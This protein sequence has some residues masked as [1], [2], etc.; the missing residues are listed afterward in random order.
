MSWTLDLGANLLDASSTRFRV[1]APFAR[2]IDVELISQGHTRVSLHPQPEG[3]WERI[4][5]LAPPGTRYH[6]I[7]DGQTTR[8]DPASRSQPDGVHGPSEVI[9]AHAF[10]WTDQRWTGR[11]FDQFII[12]EIHTGT[13]TTEGTFDAIISRLPY[14]RD[15]VGITAIE[16]MPI[17]QFPGTRNWGYDGVYLFA[18]QANYG[19]PEGLKRLV[20]ACHEHGLAVILDVVYNH[21]GPE[22]NYLGNFG[23]YFTSRYQT[24]WGQAINYD[25]PESDPIR[26]FMISNALFW[27]TEY[28]I[29][30]LRLDAIHDIY[31]FSANPILQDIGNAIHTAANHLGRMVHLIAE[32]DR[33]DANVILPATQGGYGLDA[34]WNDDFH[35]ALHS[36]LTNERCGY[37]QDFGKLEQLGTAI[38]QGYVYSGEYS[39]FRKRRHGNSPQQCQAAQ[40]V[41]YAQNH[42]QIGNRAQGNRLS[43]LISEEALKVATAAVLLAPNI[44]MLFM[45]EE[46]GD[47]SPFHY[48]ID[49]S[50]PT[51]I[52]AV[53]Q[54]R[55]AELTA[56]GWEGET[57]DPYALE[58]FGQSQPNLDLRHTSPHHTHFR[59]TQA[60]IQLR[61]S[62][63]ALSTAKKEDTIHTRIHEESR[64]MTIVRKSH[65]GSAALIFLGFHTLPTT[66]VLKKPQGHWHLKLYA[67]V[68]NIGGLDEISPLSTLSIEE[69]GLSIKLPPYP[70]FIYTNMPH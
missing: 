65:N 10:Q 6:Y 12:Y 46:Y 3:Y 37:Y 26:H 39:A 33:N 7:L 60:L 31:D 38:K 24:P 57:P 62:H 42:D 54:G 56:F 51:L 21:L 68:Q 23:P 44:P 52:K 58:T 5:S 63:P 43:T 70:V 69:T 11:P 13:F 59:W 14:L 15:E 47:P 49:H 50:D 27:I 28:H 19:G 29:D 20:D 8:P 18:P 67:N 61:K 1:W 53:Q 41:V 40:F 35:H 25:G 2:T 55:S 30:G 9:D 17:A 16:L 66:V 34:Q 32:S 36:L 45:G 64:T 22:G 48:F 4:H